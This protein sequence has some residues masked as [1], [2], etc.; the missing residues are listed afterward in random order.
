MAT[1]A[2]LEGNMDDMHKEFQS[3]DDDRNVTEINETFNM[4]DEEIV[5]W[6]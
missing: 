6:D 5:R 1:L 2:Q 4:E 3:I